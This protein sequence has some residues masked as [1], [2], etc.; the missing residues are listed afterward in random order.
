[1]CISSVFSYTVPLLFMCDFFFRQYINP[2]DSFLL[3]LHESCTILSGS[4]PAHFVLRP[5]LLVDELFP[6]R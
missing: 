2:I 5:P 1:M 6:T 3:T 4:S